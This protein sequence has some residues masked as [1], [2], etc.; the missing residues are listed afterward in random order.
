MM[1]C[2]RRLGRVSIAQF[3]TNRMSLVLCEV[4][5]KFADLQWFILADVWSINRYIDQFLYISWVI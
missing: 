3:D 5:H 1:L 2:R 4:R